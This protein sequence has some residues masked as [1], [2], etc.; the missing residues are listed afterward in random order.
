M[1]KPISVTLTLLLE[2]AEAL[3]LLGV[4]GRLSLQN[5]PQAAAILL[6]GKP[7]EQAGTSALSKLRRA[8]A[9]ATGK[10]LT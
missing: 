5:D 3:L 6:G 1:I 10:R 4:S 2:E 9:R 8:I 7:G